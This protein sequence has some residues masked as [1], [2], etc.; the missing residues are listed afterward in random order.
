MR[1]FG[2]LEVPQIPVIPDTT[3]NLLITA[4]SQQAFDYPAGTDLFRIT[5]SSTFAGVPGP[6]AFNPSSTAAAL[7]A[8]GQT[9]ASSSAGGQNILMSVGDSRMYQRPRGSTGFSIISGSSHSV[10]MEF[11][12]RAG[13]TG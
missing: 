2:T 3:L 7:P 1:Y 4:A 6:V 5:V 11:W 8:T 10:G 13:T 9:S 12:S